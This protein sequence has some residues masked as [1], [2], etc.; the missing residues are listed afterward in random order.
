MSTMQMAGAIVIDGPLPTPPAY[1]LDTVATLVP[2]DPHWRA[3]AHVY[4]Y[5][6]GLPSAIDPCADG[7]FRDKGDPDPNVSPFPFPAFTAFLGEICSAM[8]VGSWDD[9][10][11]R[12]NFA[13]AARDNWIMERQLV[14]GTFVDAPHLGDGTADIQASGAALAARVAISYLENAIAETGQQGV[15]HI[16]PAVAV[17]ASDVFHDDRSVLRTVNGTPVI[18]GHGYVNADGPE[19]GSPAGDGQDWIYASGPVLYRRDPNLIN[20]PETFAEALD[21]GDNTVVYRAERDVWVGWDGQLQ[22]AALADWTPA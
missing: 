5:V 4:P 17:A 8:G 22:A 19:G 7:T 14:N 20:L 6:P 15:L 9:F 18:V 13:L 2:D 1:A 10:R 12:A 3:G 11:Q 16:T 21:R